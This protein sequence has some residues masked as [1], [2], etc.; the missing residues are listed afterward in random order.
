MRSLH[1]FVCEP[2]DGRRYDNTKDLAGKQ[3][4]TS[5]TDEDHSVTNRIAIVKSTP[6]KYDGP[7]QSGDEL[8]VHHNI[9]RI[10]HDMKGREKSS[11]A[12]L[13]GN[14]FLIDPFDI[15]AYKRSGD[16]FIALHPYVFIAPVDKVSKSI[17]EDSRTTEELTGVIVYSN[18]D[19]KDLKIGDLV[20][21]KP[22]IEYEFNID[23]KK[24][25]RLNV[26][27]ICLVD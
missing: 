10:Y 9:F 12:H 19:H 5:S 27:N 11:Y 13:F 24:L 1:H 17:I 18:N 14:T 15:Y 4:V 2:K 6:I 25:Y 22:H 26:N 20:K 3:F 7:I 8:I 21:Y 16:G 23:G